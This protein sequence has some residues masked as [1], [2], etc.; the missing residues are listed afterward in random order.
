MRSSLR[1]TNAPRET[2]L[3]TVFRATRRGSTRKGLL[4][5]MAAVLAGGG[6]FLAARDASASHPDPR[7]DAHSHHVASAD[8]Y[9]E[10]PRVAAIYTQAQEIKVVLDGLYCYCNCSEHSG[11]YSLLDCFADDHAARCDICLSEAALAW[12]MTGQGKSL[13]QV[14]DA[15]DNMYGR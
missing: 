3:R 5:A 9:G 4:W 7:P 6:G 13:D 2:G 8:R 14:R 15:I 12:Q 10:Y 11:H 1:R